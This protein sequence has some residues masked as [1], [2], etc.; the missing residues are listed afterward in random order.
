MNICTGHLIAQLAYFLT[1]TCLVDLSSDFSS[2]D[3]FGLLNVCPEASPFND[4]KN[5]LA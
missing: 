5:N 1:C 4:Y 2:H 3:P